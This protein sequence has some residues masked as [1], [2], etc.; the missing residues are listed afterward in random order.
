MSMAFPPQLMLRLSRQYLVTR[1][2][3]ALTGSTTRRWGWYLERRGYAS[4]HFPLDPDLRYNSMEMTAL[5]YCQYQ[6]YPLLKRYN[7]NSIS[8]QW[9]YFITSLC[10]YVTIRSCTHL[11][12]S[13][14]IHLVTHIYINNWHI[15]L[16]TFSEDKVA[17]VNLYRAIQHGQP[18]AARKIL[19]NR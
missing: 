9:S 3:S 6:I 1:A 17:I 7:Y 19:T 16:F 10:V 18:K 2:F 11:S 14:L 4:H 5:I 13:P 15:S 8:Q 12:I